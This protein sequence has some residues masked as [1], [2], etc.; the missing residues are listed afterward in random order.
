L[1][2]TRHLVR[3][4]CLGAR[5]NPR[6]LVPYMPSQST[7]QSLRREVGFRR[8]APAPAVP[9][10]A[11]KPYEDILLELPPRARIV[12]ADGEGPAPVRKRGRTCEADPITIMNAV[13]FSRFL[14]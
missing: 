14:R 5:V 11:L 10:T 4:A 8:V 12:D 2:G 1:R 3:S 13:A 6:Q 9:P 7:I